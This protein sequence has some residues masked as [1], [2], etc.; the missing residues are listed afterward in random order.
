MIVLENVTKTYFSTKQTLTAVDNVSLTFTDN[1]IY[2]IIGASGAGKSTLIR[3]LNGL[4]PATTGNIIIDGLPLTRM[5]GK[6]LRQLRTN[7]GMVFQQFNLLSQLNV[8]QN[9]KTALLAAKFPKEKINERINEVLSLVKLEGKI[10]SYPSELSGG[11]KQR[12]GIARAIAAKPKYLLCDEITSALDHNIAIEIIDTLKEIQ[13]KEQMT[14]IFITHQ[15]EM[16]KRLCDQLIVMED[17]QV[18]EQGLTK[19]I[20]VNPQHL[21]TK[22]LINNVLEIPVIKEEDYYR[23]IYDNETCGASTL[24][25][26]VKKYDIST[27]IIYAK[28]LDINN[29]TIGILITQI[30]G[31]KV[32][33]A[34]KYLQSQKVGVYDVR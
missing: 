28:T 16:A 31:K 10:K 25:D 14:I 3:L 34:L 4:I 13:T 19:D 23:L 32:K 26:A 5:R 30:K 27:N 33:A 12:L 8:Y 1:L 22:N 9:I 17:A 6:D 20:F 18:I 7:M 11:Q 24:T 15:L 29:E 2:G 21:T